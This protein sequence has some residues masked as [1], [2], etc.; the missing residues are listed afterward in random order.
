MRKNKKE[1]PTEFLPARTREVYSSVFG[2][3]E[4]LT[5]VSYVPKKGKSVILLSSNHRDAELSN[6]FD[7][8][9]QTNLD[10]NSTKGGVDTLDQM[11][12]T[13]STKRMTRRW[14][15]VIFYNIL[16]ISAVNAFVIWMHLN[17][18]WNKQKTHRRRVF[19]KELGKSLVAN[20]LKSRLIL[21]NLSLK[22]HDSIC[23]SLKNIEKGSSMSFDEPQ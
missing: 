16:D 6:R 20:Q 13:F 4:Q 22:L 15:M 18:T 3:Q 8:K 14:P 12:S 2:H 5:L 9:P 10:Y 21:P 17:P 19:L 11:V 23:E 7:K 1:I